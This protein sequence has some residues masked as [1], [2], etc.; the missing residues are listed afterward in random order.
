MFDRQWEIG[1]EFKIQHKELEFKQL[2]SLMEE[3]YIN[4][5]LE[6]GT[7]T[8]GTAAAFASMP[9]KVTSLDIEKFPEH[10]FLR[11]RFTDSID[12]VLGDSSK[13]DIVSFVYNLIRPLPLEND[14]YHGTVDMLYIDGDHSYQRSMHDYVSY[15]DL[16]KPGGLI[17]FHDIV[18]SSL[19]RKQNCEVWKTW[20]EV[21]NDYGGKWLEIVSEDS[22]WGGLGL[23]FT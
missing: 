6:I 13:L 7:N 3:K 12:L 8:G 18:K 2:L 15:R 14:P 21:R 1:K 11:K 22:I 23:I 5:V 19:H 9:C 16:V 4:S 20:R 17:V 10:E